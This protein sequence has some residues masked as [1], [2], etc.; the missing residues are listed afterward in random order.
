MKTI[1][2]AINED[3]ELIMATEDQFDFDEMLGV[4]CALLQG[5]MERAAGDNL[6]LRKELYS[7]VNYRMSAMLAE[8]IP[9]ATWL[10]PSESTPIK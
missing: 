4:A 6:I 2:L 5:V 3:R 10:E 1:H 9:D 8:Y 7:R